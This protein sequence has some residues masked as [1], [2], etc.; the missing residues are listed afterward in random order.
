MKE[1]VEK[2]KN[3]GKQHSYVEIV[4]GLKKDSSDQSRSLARRLIRGPRKVGG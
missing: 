1:N 2:Q 4:K 3:K